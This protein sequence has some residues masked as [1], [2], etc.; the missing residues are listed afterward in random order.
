MSNTSDKSG[1]L[2]P[3]DLSSYTYGTGGTVARLNSSAIGRNA[4]PP[5]SSIGLLTAADDYAS[6]DPVRMAT[7]LDWADKDYNH[8]LY[9]LAIGGPRRLSTIAD[10][11]SSVTGRNI[12]VIHY[13]GGY[14]I[15]PPL[16]SVINKLGIDLSYLHK[17]G[18][19]LY[20]YLLDNRFRNTYVKWLNTLMTLSRMVAP[21]HFIDAGAQPLQTFVG[22]ISGNILTV[23]YIGSSP[24]A[25][26]YAI[27]G[28]GVDPHTIVTGFVSSSGTFGGNGQYTLNISQYIAPG[29]SMYPITPQ[30]NPG[31][32]VGAWALMSGD[33]YSLPLAE[34]NAISDF[35]ASP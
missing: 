25:I 13:E 10:A 4:V 35:N 9:Y 34:F 12:G 26:G 30:S 16:A 19:L 20:G 33:I 6:G 31:T 5:Y 32:G 11:W 3:S 15:N 23:T 21:S 2:I 8:S 7:A 24:L 27:G 18:S 1:N 29:T 14:E 28:V 17:I 22:G